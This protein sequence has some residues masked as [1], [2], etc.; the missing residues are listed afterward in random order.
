MILSRSIL[1]ITGLI[2]AFVNPLGQIARQRCV[3]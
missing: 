1:A 3:A 2:R